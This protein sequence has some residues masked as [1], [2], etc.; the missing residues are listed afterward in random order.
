MEPTGRSGQINLRRG[1][2]RGGR[3]RSVELDKPRRRQ[4]FRRLDAPSPRRF[5]LQVSRFRAIMR[6]RRFEMKESA[7]LW[8]GSTEWLTNSG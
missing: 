8:V 1:H 6:S 5:D 7:T 3:T 2:V 4:R